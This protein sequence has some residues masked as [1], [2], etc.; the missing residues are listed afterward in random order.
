MKYKDL[1]ANPP[2]SR[3]EITTH[4]KQSTWQN[5]RPTLYGL[6]TREKLAALRKFKASHKGR[7]VDVVVHNYINALK[8]GGLL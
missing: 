4:I 1:L 8:R 6:S 3:E 2:P 7:W 5:F